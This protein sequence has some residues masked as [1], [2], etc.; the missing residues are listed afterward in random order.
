MRQACKTGGGVRIA[1][2]HWGWEVGG[3]VHS[4]SDQGQEFEDQHSADLNKHLDRVPRRSHYWK[5]EEKAVF[6]H[7]HPSGMMQL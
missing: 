7:P 6:S 5:N 4:D 1:S 3:G 2:G